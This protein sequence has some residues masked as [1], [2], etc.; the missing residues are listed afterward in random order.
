MRCYGR[1]ALLMIGLTGMVVSA[2]ASLAPVVS[3][4]S[5]HSA[6][7]QPNVYVVKKG[8]T[9][10]S[11]AWAFGMDYRAL[12]NTNH[13]AKPYGIYPGQKLVMKETK[14]V[15]VVAK[16]VDLPSPVV[17]PA[18]IWHKPGKIHWIWPTHGK[19]TQK[20]SKRD[21]G[22]KGVDIAG[23]LGQPVKAAASGEVVYSGDGVRGYGNL[24]I[25]R[26][27][28][29]YLS[30]Y[31]Y[32]KKLLVKVGEQVKAGQTIAEMGQTNAGKTKLHFEI[33]KQGKPVNPLSY[34][35]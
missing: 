9:L 20:F 13:L 12:A 16:E 25:I 17:L 2:Q 32:N 1:V 35:R 8:D 19:V 29:E 28:Q 15:K 27:A 10:Y 30:A 34:L 4:D 18:P 5:H 7:Q 23:K 11:I 6:S 33:R 3:I 26:H 14:P 24:I 22:N 31:A 21:D